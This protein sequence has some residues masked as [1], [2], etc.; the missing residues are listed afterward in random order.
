[1]KGKHLKMIFVILIVIFFFVIQTSDNKSTIKKSSVISGHVKG[2][3]IIQGKAIYI[4]K[5]PSDNEFKTSLIKYLSMSHVKNVDK[6]KITIT[7]KKNNLGY[8]HIH[9]SVI[10]DGDCII[11]EGNAYNATPAQAEILRVFDDAES[12]NITAEGGHGFVECTQPPNVSKYQGSP[13]IQVNNLNYTRFNINPPSCTCNNTDCYVSTDYDSVNNSINPSVSVCESGG[14]P[15]TLEGCETKLCNKV[16]PASSVLSDAGVIL[17]TANTQQPTIGIGNRRYIKDANNLTGVQYTCRNGWS[18]NPVYSG[19]TVPDNTDQMLAYCDNS[20]DLVFGT[21]DGNTPACIQDCIT[22]ITDP[23][24]PDEQW[25]SFSNNR[26]IQENNLQSGSHFDVKMKCSDGYAWSETSISQGNMDPNGEVIMHGCNTSNLVYGGQSLSYTC[27]QHC[28]EPPVL[29]TV[30]PESCGPLGQNNQTACAAAVNNLYPSKFGPNNSTGNMKSECMNAGCE[31]IPSSRFIK[32]SDGD[33]SKSDNFNMQDNI[34]CNHDEGYISSNLPAATV[35]DT[36]G[37]DYNLHPDACIK[38]YTRVPEDRSITPPGGATTWTFDDPYV[39]APN[40]VCDNPQEPGC[41]ETLDDAS[42]Q[43]TI[44]CNPNAAANTGS[45]DWQHPVYEGNPNININSSAN[46]GDETN[47]TFKVDGCLPIC[48]E[49]FGCINHTIVKNINQ[50][51]DQDTE[52]QTILDSYLPGGDESQGGRVTGILTKEHVSFWRNYE[53]NNQMFIEMQLSCNPELDGCVILTDDDLRVNPC[54]ANAGD[55]IRLADSNAP[56]TAI[57]YIVP[58]GGDV[59]NGHGVCSYYP[60]PDG[61]N[62]GRDIASCG[63][64]GEWHGISCNVSPCVPSN[65]CLNGGTCNLAVGDDTHTCTCAGEWSGPNC[66]SRNCVITDFDHAWRNAECRSDY[67][68]GAGCNK[69]IFANPTNQASGGGKSCQDA[70]NEMSQVIAANSN[71][72]IT[73][74]PS[75]LAL[76]KV[77]NCPAGATCDDTDGYCR[78]SESCPGNYGDPCFDACMVRSGC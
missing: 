10:C 62:D 44:T 67:H 42:H 77:C 30:I 56:H 73:V 34:D 16:D 6:N 11:V 14:S 3:Q 76:E 49:G 70:F 45:Q 52:I 59:C 53:F 74:I 27:D 28:T 37:A 60:A 18:K 78:A 47:L 69:R 63:C 8:T 12:V 35:C 51:R 23:Q 29:A 13:G 7:R 5:P 46:D 43:P 55:T 41:L 21:L 25:C 54:D 72:D 48:Q 71:S 15:Y 50:Y 4:S 22:K 19:P 9:F 2:P 57:E 26:S 1:M 66:S 58:V 64:V 39:N 65:P 36:A 24:C 40:G 32:N 17:T 38:K 33:R 68:T 20:D 31:Y 61:D 75:S